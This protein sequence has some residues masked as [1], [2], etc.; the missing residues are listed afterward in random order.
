M[1]SHDGGHEQA[2]FDE[3]K[4]LFRSDKKTETKLG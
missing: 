2:I 1:D 4:N 3:H